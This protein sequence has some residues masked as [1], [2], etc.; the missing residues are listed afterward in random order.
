M[1][2]QPN[3]TT[4]KPGVNDEVIQTTA[5]R[6]IAHE[7]LA[8]QSS[9]IGTLF[10]QEPIEGFTIDE[11]LNAYTELEDGESEP[12]EI[13]EWWLVTRWLAEKL[14]AIGQPVLDNGY[15][16]WWGRTCTG[17]AIVMD[18]TMQEVARLIHRDD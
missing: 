16:H 4:Q 12:Q 3:Q 15:G 8:C 13:F 1:N 9:L 10:S 18:G 5:E 6:L 7:V 14:V 17:Q 11:L 2:T